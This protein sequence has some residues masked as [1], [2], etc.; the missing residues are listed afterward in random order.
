M[1]FEVELVTKGVPPLLYSS[2]SS[3]HCLGRVAGGEA[4]VHKLQKDNVQAG[5]GGEAYAFGLELALERVN[6]DAIQDAA[7]NVPLPHTC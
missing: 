1:R 5:D 7:E 6:V 3:L 2:D 4:V